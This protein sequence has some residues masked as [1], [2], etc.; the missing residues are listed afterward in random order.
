[1]SQLIKLRSWS[2]GNSF[3]FLAF[4]NDFII[5]ALWLKK[6]LKNNLQC[7][8]S[9]FRESTPGNPKNPFP[10]KTIL[11]IHF[12][13][14]NPKFFSEDTCRHDMRI[15]S[16]GRFQIYRSCS[17]QYGAEPFS[18]TFFREILEY[19]KLCKTAKKS[20]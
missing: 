8:R 6:N 14:I 2:F 3:I 16:G 10:F 1:M 13:L 11:N 15:L 17:K 12:I 9:E 4:I 7:I 5:E 19:P 20:F 18:K